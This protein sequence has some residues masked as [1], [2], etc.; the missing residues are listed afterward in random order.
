M[1]APLRDDELA[2][3]CSIG[4]PHGTPGFDRDGGRT[5]H[6]FALLISGDTDESDAA[7][8]RCLSDVC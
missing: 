5:E 2:K 6:R 8:A 3:C 4:D 7:T 1:E